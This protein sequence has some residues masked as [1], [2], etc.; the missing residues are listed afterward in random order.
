MIDLHAHILPDVDDGPL[1]LEE[2]LDMIRAGYREGID[3]VCA[4]PHLLE[5]PGQG[6]IDLFVQRLEQLKDGIKAEGLPV[7]V[8]LG[9]EVYFQPDMERVLDYPLLTINGTGKYL[10]TEFPM[11]S[12]PQG[13]DRVIF[14]LIMSGTIPIVAHPER[15][16]S[17]LKDESVLEPFVHSGAL[18]QINASSLDGRFGKGVKKC[19]LSLLK[20]GLVQLIGSDAHNASDRPVSLQS[21]VE[22]ASQVIGEGQAQD[23]VTRHP[24]RILSGEPLPFRTLQSSEEL[25]R[26]LLRK[27]WKGL[28]SK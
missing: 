21:A 18:L 10:L 24:H 13:A 23:L 9:A 14:N 22:T 16:L 4:T 12:I 15:N 6:R 17:V 5:R 20:K 2:S 11:Q 27:I 1:D 25:E 7:N 26:P 3:T 8:L 19:A 28:T